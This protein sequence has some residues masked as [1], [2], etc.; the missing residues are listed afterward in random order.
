MLPHIIFEV[1]FTLT[2]IRIGENSSV[3]IA[4]M[5]G[6]RIF[7][8]CC[9]IV[10]LF[11]KL[12]GPLVELQDLL[13]MPLILQISKLLQKFKIFWVAM[14]LL[15]MCFSVLMFLKQNRYMY[16]ARHPAHHLEVVYQRTMASEQRHYRTL[17]FF[18]WRSSREC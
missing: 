16:I 7:F 5:F 14:T 6:M 1:K 11:T 17:R 4:L 8:F 13:C 2:L 15:I 3:L 9:N 12:D 10:H 18:S